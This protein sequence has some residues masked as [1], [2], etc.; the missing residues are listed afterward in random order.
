MNDR[1]DLV[2]PITVASAIAGLL[3]Y[4]Y[5]EDPLFAVGNTSQKHIH[6]I[7]GSIP[8][9][10]DTLV[11]STKLDGIH[12]YILEM[13]EKHGNEPWMV[14]LPFSPVMVVV[15]DPAAVEC[16]LKTK[17]SV[18]DKGPRF[19]AAFHDLLG[20]GIFNADGEEWKSQRKLAANIFNV[21]NFKDYV[22]NVFSAE[23]QAFSEI[24]DGYAETGKPFDL[25]EYFF[26]FTFDSFT[27][28]GFGVEVDTISDV[29]STIPF[30]AAFDTVQKRISRRIFTPL[31]QYIEYLSGEAKENEAQIK[32]IRDFGHSII[33]KKKESGFASESD[34]LA[35]LMNVK[36]DDG[37]P[38]SDETLVDYALNF[39]LAGR[40]TTACA[41]SW[42]VFLLHKNPKA[43]ASLMNE[44]HTVTNN[45]APTY[46]QIKNEMPYA[47]A[48]FHETLRLYP[49]VPANVKQANADV[50]L[51]DGT[52][53][54]KGCCVTWSPY[55]MGRTPAIWGDDAKEFKPER[56]LSME[57]QPSPFD[58]PAFQGGPRICLGKSM[59]ELEG[60][61]VLVELMRRYKIEVVN[62]S[63][64]GYAFSVLLP[65]KN[66]LSVKCSLRE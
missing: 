36:G 1:I 31:W 24:L 33:Q 4:V 23:M 18:F 27:R 39:L 3:T 37:S 19:Q 38:P 61:Y 63:E 11:V 52:F 65:M 25:Q 28:I 9:L 21:K 29:S 8:F 44:I 50:T 60:V 48:V 30:M 12:D 6:R 62:E 53:I 40:D 35:L 43:Q 32:L 49:S 51:P 7:G 20:H 15:N 5:R 17:F 45:A 16:V 14:K 13:F 54:P 57:K 34:L 22:R 59:A 26:R 58:Y 47:N 46:D 56:W 41:L 2:A 10:G 64:V 55:A 42:A 66:G